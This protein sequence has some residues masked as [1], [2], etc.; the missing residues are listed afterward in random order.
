MLPTI[1]Q[2]VAYCEVRTMNSCTRFKRNCAR[3]HL[4]MN[5][6]YFEASKYN[7]SKILIKVYYSLLRVDTYNT[8]THTHT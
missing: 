7:M 1:I 2:G 4:E 8:H 3:N 5:E 6:N